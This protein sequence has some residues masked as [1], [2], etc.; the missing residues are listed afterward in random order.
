MSRI[1]PRL[2]VRRG[3]RDAGSLAA[4]MRRWLSRCWHDAA[5]AGAFVLAAMVLMRARREGA[6]AG[7]KPWLGFAALLALVSQPHRFVVCCRKI[8][9]V[10]ASPIAPASLE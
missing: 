5:C 7:K 10:P 8:G 2:A 1:S 9:D 3:V 6:H 4:A